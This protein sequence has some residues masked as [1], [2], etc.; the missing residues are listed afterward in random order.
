[1]R[2]P[3]SYGATTAHDVHQH[4]NVTVDDEEVDAV[5]DTLTSFLND[6]LATL[7]QHLYPRLCKDL[8]RKTWKSYLGV[9]ETMLTPALFGDPVIAPLNRAKPL[10]Q[11]Q[12]LFLDKCLDIMKHFFHADGSGIPIQVLESPKYVE[13]KCTMSLYWQS[14]TEIQNAYVSVVEQQELHPKKMPMEWSD[15]VLMSMSMDEKK[16]SLSPDYML[17]ILRLRMSTMSEGRLQAQHFFA[18]QMRLRQ[19]RLRWTDDQ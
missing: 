12:V 8:L 3:F 4:H 13:L 6:A 14:I 16:S 7:S 19:E 18:T 9:V 2:L 5:M 10:T 15:Q 17:R 11:R 1:L